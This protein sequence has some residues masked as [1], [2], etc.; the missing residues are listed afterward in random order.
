MSNSRVRWTVQHDRP[1]RIGSEGT[2]AQIRASGGDAGSLARLTAASKRNSIEN[3]L[4]LRA[5]L[6][7]IGAERVGEHGEAR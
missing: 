2:V 6:F 4:R 3:V 5:G 1:E 7:D